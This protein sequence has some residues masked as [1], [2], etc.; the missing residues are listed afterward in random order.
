MKRLDL[1]EQ[2]AMI[3]VE[4][5]ESSLSDLVTETAATENRELRAA[6]KARKSFVRDI[7][8]R[9]GSSEEKLTA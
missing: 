3:L 2:E 9:L 7:L 8:T 4:V 1:T 6:L 5:L